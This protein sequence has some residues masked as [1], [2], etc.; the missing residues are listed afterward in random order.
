MHVELID[1]LAG[2]VL[3]AGMLY[4]LRVAFLRL[5]G[6]EALGMGDVKL[7]AA[8]GLWGGGWNVPLVLALAALM[9]LL[10]IMGLRGAGRF[11]GEAGSLRD[12]RRG[13]W[14]R[15]DWRRHRP[16]H[17]RRHRFHY[18]RRE[19]RKWRSLCRVRLRDRGVGERDSRRWTRQ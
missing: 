5:R 8:A 1:A 17:R 14:R 3:G 6:V 19:V 7:M 15:K 10:A 12:T 4:A 16:R 11:Q 2:A 9:T 13:P 18:R